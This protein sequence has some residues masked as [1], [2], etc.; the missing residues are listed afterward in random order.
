VILMLLLL[1]LPLLL[2][3]LGTFKVGGFASLSTSKLVLAAGLL[4]G[5]LVAF[6]PSCGAI[7]GSLWDHHA[8]CH[9]W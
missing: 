7:V 6:G 9:R 5:I 8:T 4:D 2:L 3:L 1:L